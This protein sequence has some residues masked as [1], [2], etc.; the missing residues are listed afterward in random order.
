MFSY[1]QPNWTE[2]WITI[3]LFVVLFY[4]FRTILLNQSFKNNA[5][6][7]FLFA[8]WY[9]VTYFLLFLFTSYKYQ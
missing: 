5:Y 6:I 9:S 1:L 3:C 7:V 2:Y 4:I 8:L